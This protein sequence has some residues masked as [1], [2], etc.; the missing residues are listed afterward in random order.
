[1]SL[2]KSI[3]IS[4]NWF[5]GW[6]PVSNS[7]IRVL[8]ESEL[9]YRRW[10]R[11]TRSWFVIYRFHTTFQD[12]MSLQKSILVSQNRYNSWMP[13]KIPMARVLIESGQNYLRGS[14]ITWSWF[15]IYRYSTT[16]QGCMSL[17]K[18]ILVSQNRFKGC[19]PVH[20]S[21]IWAIYWSEYLSGFFFL[22]Q[23]CVRLRFW[24][25][26]VDSDGKK[27]PKTDLLTLISTCAAR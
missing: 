1:M 26:V 16:F 23:T 24:V 19:M 17:R 21:L 2:R 18:S 12:C 5:N 22:I 10:S 9:N 7:L 25:N 11:I 4:Q 20:I 15:D 8:I 6:I 27:S 3:L 13:V 14:R